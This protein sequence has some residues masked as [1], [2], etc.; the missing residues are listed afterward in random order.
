M[1]KS[2][3]R[4]RSGTADF[5]PAADVYATRSVRGSR[6]GTVQAAEWDRL[7]SPAEGEKVTKEDE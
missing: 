1:L 3:P 7:A 6:P 2:A 4:V 5:D